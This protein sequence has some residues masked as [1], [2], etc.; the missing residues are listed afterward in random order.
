M[1]PDN[2]DPTRIFTKFMQFKD[3]MEREIVKGNMDFFSQANVKKPEH[4]KNPYSTQGVCAILLWNALMPS[5]QLEFPTDIN[6]VPIKEL[7][8]V[9]ENKDLGPAMYGA[10]R[11]V[12]SPYESS[13]NLMWYKTNFP[14]A[15]ENLHRNIFCS[16]NP[17]IQHMNLS[18]IAIPKNPDYEIPKFITELF[19]FEG[20]VNKALS[21]G[22]P[23]LRSVGIQSFQV[24]SNLEH[25]TNIVSL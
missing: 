25:A 4:Y 21:L 9:K 7:T 5:K 17:L 18:S 3:Y 8:W 6:I 12:K 11:A 10:V 22:V 13:K 15:Y 1:Y 14:E 24:T 19:D 2:I 20:V 23:L 16:T